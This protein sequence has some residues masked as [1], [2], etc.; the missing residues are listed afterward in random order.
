[1]P[2]HDSRKPPKVRYVVISRQKGELISERRKQEMNFGANR[3]VDFFVEI[4]SDKKP[5]DTQRSGEFRIDFMP[6]APDELTLKI[7]GPI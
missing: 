3:H 7:W 5:S 2:A 4:S 6:V 1:L